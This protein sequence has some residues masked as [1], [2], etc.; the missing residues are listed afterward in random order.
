MK[1]ELEKPSFD[2]RMMKRLY[3]EQHSAL[4]DQKAQGVGAFRRK[5]IQVSNLSTCS[6][7]MTISYLIC[8]IG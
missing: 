1:N 5:F 8:K 4:G 3:D 7:P 6:V 2:Q